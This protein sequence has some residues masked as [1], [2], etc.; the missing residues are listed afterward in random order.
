MVPAYGMEMVMNS[1]ISDLIT[2]GTVQKTNEGTVR[3]SVGLKTQRLLHAP[4]LQLEMAQYGTNE[5]VRN[6]KLHAASALIDSLPFFHNYSIVGWLLT[7]L[8]GHQGLAVMPS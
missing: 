8:E 2:Y 4:V 7:R 3:E 6:N 1:I 5:S